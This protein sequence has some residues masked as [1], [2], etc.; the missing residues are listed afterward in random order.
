M[1]D[2]KIRQI[3]KEEIGQQKLTSQFTV[4]AVSNHIHNDK[5]S[6]KISFNNLINKYLVIPVTIQGI[7]AQT[8]T[9]YNVFFIAPFSMTISGVTEVHT[10]AGTNGSAVT[11][12]IEKLI[13]NVAPGSGIKLLSTPFNLKNTLNTVQTGILSP[14]TGIVQLNKGDRLAL[15]VSGTLT[16]LSNVTVTLLVNF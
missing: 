9:N 5:N 7:Q 14:I 11:L 3:V 15:L 13:N 16:S 4:S 10:I 6:R 2:E 8:A 1:Q 12:Q